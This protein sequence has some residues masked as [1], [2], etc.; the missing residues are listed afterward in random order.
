MTKTRQVALIGAGFIAGAHA[1]ALRT[2]KDAAISAVVD[3][4]PTR[5]GELARKV[6][7]A[8]FATV[9][10]LLAKARPEAAHVLTP[11]PTHAAVASELL[12]AGVDV[13]LEKPMAETAGDCDR[14]VAA[15]KQSGAA[16]WVNHNFRF[17]PVYLRAKAYVLS[18]R[19]G[20]P[21]QA[22]M[23]YAAALRQ[24]SARQF[25]HWMFESP[26]NLLL[27]QVVHPLS[28]IDDLLGG[29]GS[30][31]ATAA[32]PLSPA[33]GVSVA[34]EWSLSLR[35]RDGGADLAVTLG[36]N[37][38]SWTLS[39]LC[40]DGAI[41]ADIF[42][43]RVAA[44][45]PHSA[46]APLDHAAR[47]FETGVAGV[48]ETA[49]GLSE[50]A[51]ELARVRPLSD[52]FNR[53]MTGSI[54]AFHDALDSQQ[55]TIG[56][57]GPRL[58]RICDEAARAAKIDAP[59]QIRAP[60]AQERFDVAVAGGTGFIG[61]HLVSR[62]LRDGRRVAVFARGA[63][64]LPSVFHDPNVAVFRGSIS[65]AA[66]LDQAFARAR[67]VV[68]LAHGGGG[69]TRE[70]I[71]AAMVD[72][73]RAAR[74]AAARAGCERVV[75]ASSSAALYLGDPGETVTMATPPDAEPDQRGDY[76]RAKILAELAMAEPGA[77]TVIVRPAVVVGEGASPFHSALGAFEND[78]HCA[79]WNEGRNPLP[80][81]LVEDVAEAIV[82]A[83]EVEL[84]S[85]AGK[86][87]NLVGDVRWSARRYLEELAVATGRPLKFHPSSVAGLM[88]SERLKWAVKKAAGRA[89]VVAPSERDIR[90]RGMVAKFDASDE[91]RILGWAPCA[92][93]ATFR[94]RAILAHARSDK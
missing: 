8:P 93:E 88:A 61:A 13:L 48:M 67:Q 82:K 31:V 40:D 72:G 71:E 56:E 80:F 77:P 55:R 23:R 44:R 25:G 27:E 63:R 81:V 10:D 84:Q 76:A 83:L 6:N 5:A 22:Q 30:V 92:D 46:I 59:K 70:A 9:A 75:F 28:I 20:R 74:D 60:S 34:A 68:V 57:D 12:R 18:G 49:R 43:G 58:V 38:P 94:A 79:G 19:F 69:A 86:A 42:E 7:A 33:A 64:N 52:G 11:P 3:P 41:D 32:P 1:A 39:I 2:R 85:V 89:G 54:A 21:R 17:H 29:I 90:S 24:L 51:L 35:C 14:L 45:R 62:L 15:A 87:L 53:S 66:A 73:A 91:K 16:L 37:F 50:F 4:D 36:A 26:R 78:T 47:N 65:D